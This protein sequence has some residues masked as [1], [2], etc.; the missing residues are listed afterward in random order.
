MK[1]DTLIGQ[2]LLLCLAQVGLAF[3][4]I[5]SLLTIFQKAGRT[6]E[7]RD[8]IGMKFMLE[9][10][11][12]LLVYAIQPF[13]W[14]YLSDSINSLIRAYSSRVFDTQ[15]IAIMISSLTLSVFFVW[16][17]IK[18]R[19]R[20]LELARENQKPTYDRRLRLI[21]LPI[22]WLLALIL[23]ANT[24]KGLFGIYILGL[25]WQL[26]MAVVQFAVFVIVL[27][28]SNS[29]TVSREVPTARLLQGDSSKEG[30]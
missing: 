11:I 23:L 4:G 17:A 25:A 16:Q 15:K 20:R 30:L 28:K 1:G 14:F 24:L 9:N 22:T 18:H 13:L 5:S 26:T 10:N 19:Q 2:E 7:M 29:L 6:W 12:G 3:S 8:I 27:T 21:V